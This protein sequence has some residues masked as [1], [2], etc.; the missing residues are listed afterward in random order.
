MIS[1]LVHK[2]SLNE[3]LKIMI[4]FSLGMVHQTPLMP[5]PIFLNQLH[6]QGVLVDCSQSTGNF[7]NINSEIT[8]HMIK[9]KQSNTHTKL[10]HELCW[11][12]LLSN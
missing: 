1:I 9:T 6:L 5:C 2:R 4:P 10:V 11:R 7:F 3:F 8:S 12:N